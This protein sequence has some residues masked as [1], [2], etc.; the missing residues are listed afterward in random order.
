[1]RLC[2][3]FS[4]VVLVFALFSGRA[5]AQYDS[6]ACCFE[7]GICEVRALEECYGAPGARYWTQGSGCDPNPCQVITPHLACCLPDGSCTILNYLVCEDSGGMA[8]WWGGCDP[9]PCGEHL[10][11]CCLASG[12]CDL[13]IPSVCEYL[14]GEPAAPTSCDPNPCGSEPGACCIVPGTCVILTFDACYHAEDSYAWLEDQPCSP[15]PC[16]NTPMVA[17]CF[18]DGHCERIPDFACEDQGGSNAGYWIDCSPNPCA[19]TPLEVGSWGRI[20]SFYR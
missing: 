13:L 17:C 20:K 2:P 4:S 9:D 15:N 7:G 16:P 12:V 11:A 8:Q 6:G 10:Q 19:P 5:L 18:A 1:M 3:L 14:G